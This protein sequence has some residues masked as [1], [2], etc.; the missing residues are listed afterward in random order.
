MEN[1]TKQEHDKIRAA[2]LYMIRM[3]VFFGTQAMAL[4][5]EPGHSYKWAMGTNGKRIVFN[6]QLTK[7]FSL[8]NAVAVVLHE[9]LHVILFHHLRKGMRNHR[10]WNRA[11][12]YVVNLLILDIIKEFKDNKIGVALPDGCLIDEKFR[13]MSAEQIYDLIP[14]QAG[15]DKSEPGEDGDSGGEGGEFLPGSGCGNVEDATEGM[16]ESDITNAESKIRAS[17]KVAAALASK[18]G[19]MGNTLERLIE[20]ICEPKEDWRSRLQKYLTERAEIDYCWARPDRRVLNQFGII[21]PTLDG[22]K[23]GKIVIVADASQS[24]YADQEQFCSEVSDILAAYECEVTV[25]FHDTRVTAVDHYSSDDLPI[26]MR[27]AGF[28]GT[29]CKEAYEMAIDL[30]PDILIHLT[31]LELS[32]GGIPVPT[33][34]VLIGCSRKKYFHNCP[35]WATLLDIS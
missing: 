22:E 24:C 14:D 2:R 13:G 17:V 20:A 10:K 11:C 16:S 4:P 15:D 34:D 12:D 35:S 32:W 25:I 30:Y 29:D 19:Q 5:L 31:D 6:P 18:A 7:F 9:V 33:C 8:G 23:I 26:I 21:F 1:L 27:P 28:G 3:L